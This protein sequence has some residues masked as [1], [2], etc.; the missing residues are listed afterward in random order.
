[1]LSYFILFAIINVLSAFKDCGLIHFLD[2]DQK[3][4]SQSRSLWPW[5]FVPQTPKTFRIIHLSWSI[6]LQ[7]MKTFD[8]VGTLTFVPLTPKP[9]RVIYQYLRLIANMSFRIITRFQSEPKITNMVAG[10]LT[11]VQQIPKPIEVIY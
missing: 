8:I 9:I 6:S 3:E 4:T 7:S 2:I 10:T 1:M 11:F 5:P